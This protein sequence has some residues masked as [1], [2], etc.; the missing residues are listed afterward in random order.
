MKERDTKNVRKLTIIWGISSEICLGS[1]LFIWL[2]IPKTVFHVFLGR[3]GS[4]GIVVAAFLATA[5]GIFV[6]ALPKKISPT[7]RRSISVPISIIGT[8]AGVIAIMGIFVDKHGLW[9]LVG[10]GAVGMHIVAWG[11]SRSK[12]TSILARNES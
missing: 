4:V 12:T 10:Y 6:A 5:V 2:T 7:L 3:G 8:G 1:I 11:I 9:V